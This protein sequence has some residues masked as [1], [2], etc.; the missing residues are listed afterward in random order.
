MPTQSQHKILFLDDEQQILNGVSRALRNFPWVISFCIS[1]I[2]AL[3]LVKRNNYHL[4][5]SDYRLVE[6]NGID[7]LKETMNY[8]SNSIR[9]VLSGYAEED[10][11]QKA[12]RERIIHQYLQKPIR[13][14]RLKEE[15]EAAL[16]IKT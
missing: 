6:M 5:I 1:P 13:L 16:S 11:I 3:E 2:E 8:S 9:I 10:L 15:I 14:Q 7:F 12:K 4:I